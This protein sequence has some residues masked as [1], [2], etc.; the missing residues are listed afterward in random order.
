MY[1]DIYGENIADK[2]FSCHKTH[3]FKPKHVLQVEQT[4]ELFMLVLDFVANYKL[5]IL[6]GISV[7]SMECLKVAQNYCCVASH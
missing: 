4:T 5:K 6:N 7:E 3:C 1:G 2:N